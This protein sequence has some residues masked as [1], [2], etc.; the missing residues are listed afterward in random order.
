MTSIK[1]R[2]KDNTVLSFR[3]KYCC[4]YLNKQ[5]QRNTK[6]GGPLAAGKGNINKRYNVNQTK[7]N[8]RVCS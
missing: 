5:N 4:N 3:D 1:K 7:T 2:K 6:P 8:L